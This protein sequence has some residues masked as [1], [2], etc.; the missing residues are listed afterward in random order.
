MR[1]DAG[2]NMDEKPQSDPKPT[3]EIPKFRK[4]RFA[5]E[6]RVVSKEAL[7]ALANSD[8]FK[9]IAP[10]TKQ[11]D[12]S[13]AVI[14]SIFPKPSKEADGKGKRK[15]SVSGSRLAPEVASYAESLRSRKKP[16]DEPLEYQ[17][18]LRLSHADSYLLQIL[19]E[20]AG[21]A[22]AETIRGL[23]KDHLAKPEIKKMIEDHLKKNL[24]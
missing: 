16:K 12:D 1:S 20:I 4:S 8:V 15:A 18:S 5:S 7:D 13:N 19:S 14:N 10:E 3:I 11:T 6:E 17:T 21:H 2:Q 22:P 23:L 24:K 9:G